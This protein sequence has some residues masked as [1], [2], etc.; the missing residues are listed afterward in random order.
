M[1]PSVSIVMPCFGLGRYIEDAL[2]GVA[3]QYHGDWE[4]IAVD[5]CGPEDGTLESLETFQSSFEGGKVTIVRHEVNRGVS[6]A[7]N[8]GIQKARGKWLAFLDP[9]DVWSKAYLSELLK[10]TR[11]G[12]NRCIFFGFRS[13]VDADKRKLGIRVPAESRSDSDF[14]E[15][16]R[17]RLNRENFINPS[18]CIVPIQVREDLSPV[19]DEAPDLQHIEDWDLW[20]CLLEK[21][22]DLKFVPEAEILYRQ[23]SHNATR[24]LDMIRQR[25]ALRDKHAGNS[26]L[27]AA[28]SLQISEIQQ[29]KTFS[30]RCAKKL[31]SARTRF[32]LVLQ[33]LTRKNR[34]VRLFRRIVGRTSR[35]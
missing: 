13:L 6:A 23:H 4:L 24:R 12:E 9:D 3:E 27:H 20:L 1:I 5:D 35:S 18:Q 29:R 17:G 11:D 30:V 15:D 34:V 25:T 32:Q 7:R 28:L 8:T 31:R 14:H 16:L 22:Y 21:G 2:T 10:H 19:Y 33:R 26:S